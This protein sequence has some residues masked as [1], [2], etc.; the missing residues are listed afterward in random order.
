MRHMWQRWVSCMYRS[1]SW[2]LLIYFFFVLAFTASSTRGKHMKMVHN[3]EER[4]NRKPSERRFKCEICEQAFSRKMNLNVHMKSHSTSRGILGQDDETEE[5]PICF[6][7]IAKNS[8][9]HMKTHEKG[10]KVYEC[11]VCDAWVSSK[12]I[13]VAVRNFVSLQF[14]GSLTNP[15]VYEHICPIIRVLRILCAV[16]VRK[17]LVCPRVWQSICEFTLVKKGMAW[18]TNSSDKLINSKF[19]PQICL[20][21]LSACI[22]RLFS[23][24]SAS[25]DSH[26]WKEFLMWDLLESVLATIKS[27]ASYEGTHR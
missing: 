17:R 8:K 22:H 5:C 26:R 15:K 25:K 13:R 14:Q 1:V 27:S 2:T 9:Y 11:K 20:W 4:A 10:V 3:P 7:I 16:C 19:F 21:N 12:I 23:V 18:S 24:A 6:K